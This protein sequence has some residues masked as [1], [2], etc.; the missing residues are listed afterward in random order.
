MSKPLVS[1]VMGSDSDL[2]IIREAGKAMDE[3]GIAY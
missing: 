2:E 1:S 3:F